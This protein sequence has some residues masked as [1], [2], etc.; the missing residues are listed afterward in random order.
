MNEKESLT[1]MACCAIFIVYNTEG[2]YKNGCTA[3]VVCYGPASGG[4]A[5][6]GSFLRDPLWD[7]NPQELEGAFPLSGL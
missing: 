5:H 7:P 4:S 1:F 3:A 2:R 6:C